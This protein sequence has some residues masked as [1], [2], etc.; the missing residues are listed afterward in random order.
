MWPLA[1]EQAG[2][3]TDVCVAVARAVVADTQGDAALVFRSVV[4]TG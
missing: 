3:L 1:C 4:T 2:E